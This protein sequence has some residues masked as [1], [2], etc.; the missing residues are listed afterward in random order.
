[1]IKTVTFKNKA[2]PQFQAEGNA[3]RFAIP[4]A[5]EMLSGI[6]LDVGCSKLEWAFPGATPIDL[7]FDDE[8][9]GTNLPEGEYDYIFSSHCLEHIPDWTGVLDYWTTRLKVGGIM[10]LYLPHYSQE[11]WRPW[12]NRKHINVLS[13]EMLKDYF[14]SRNWCNIFVTE[15]YDLNNSFY[16]VAEKA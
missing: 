9:H 14:S 4:F 13:P 7:S 16:A 8:W 5:K 11:Y 15:G 12:N 2:Y 6:G 10:F 3:A 1:M